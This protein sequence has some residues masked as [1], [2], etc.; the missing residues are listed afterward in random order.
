MLFPNARICLLNR[1]FLT[2]VKRLRI[3]RTS[4]VNGIG[5]DNVQSNSLSSKSNDFLFFCSLMRFI[6]FLAAPR[7]QQTSERQMRKPI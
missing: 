3:M 6:N 4:E 5:M 2:A 1:M 7:F